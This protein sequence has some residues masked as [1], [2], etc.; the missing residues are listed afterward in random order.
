MVR[1]TRLGV[2]AELEVV[3]LAGRVGELRS[4]RRDLRPHVCGLGVRLLELPPQLLVLDLQPRV[5]VLA[6]PTCQGSG[7]R[8]QDAVPVG[9][10]GYNQ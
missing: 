7:V 3:H 2:Q 5:Q 8:G 4:E 6:R 10:V 9:G 1:R